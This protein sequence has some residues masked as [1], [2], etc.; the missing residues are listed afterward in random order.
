MIVIVIVVVFLVFLYRV[1]APPVLSGIGGPSIF[2]FRDR[3][4]NG[5]KK[6]KTF[7]SF[8]K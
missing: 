6:R 5:R 7:L 2:Q 1:C 3:T 8:S 4:L